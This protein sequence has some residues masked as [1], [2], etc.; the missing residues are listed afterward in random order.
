MTIFAIDRAT[1]VWPWRGAQMRVRSQMYY[2]PV[3][4]AQQ[5]GLPTDDPAD[6]DDL[7]ASERALSTASCKI[8]SAGHAARVHLRRS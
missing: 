3:I 6:P 7:V 1:R 4:A 8:V 2:C 5:L